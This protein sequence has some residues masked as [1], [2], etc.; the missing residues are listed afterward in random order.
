MQRLSEFYFVQLGHSPSD[1]ICQVSNHQVVMTIEGALT[2]LEKLLNT[3]HQL[4]LVTSVRAS[5]DQILQRRL[6][7]WLANVLQTE[8]I[9][10][11]VT[12]DL[13]HDRLMAI[14]IISVS[15]DAEINDRPES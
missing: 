14:A 7:A 10:L 9:E 13:A 2:G 12:T 15:P 8:V 4:S 1:V 3:H 11:F 5:L 6:K